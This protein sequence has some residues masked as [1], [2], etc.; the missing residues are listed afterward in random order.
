MECIRGKNIIFNL[1]GGP[2]PHSIELCNCNGIEIAFV[3]AATKW[4]EAD[5]ASYSVI[6]PVGCTPI[7]SAYYTVS[8]TSNCARIDDSLG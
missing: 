5:A 4:C 1:W 7:Q 2:L 8:S 6:L 3:S